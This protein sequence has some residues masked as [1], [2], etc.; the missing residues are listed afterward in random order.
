MLTTLDRYLLREVIQTWVAVTFVLL[1]IMLS[2]R[3][4][5]Y[6]GEAAAGQLPAEVV[7]TLLGLTS[8]QY[9]TVLVP[10]SLFLAVMLALGRFYRDSEMVA[11]MACGIGYGRLLKPLM[12]LA[13]TIGV[14]LAALSLQVGPWAARMASEVRAGAEREVESAGFEAGRFR[15]GGETVYYAEQVSDSGRELRDVF[16]EQR[17]GDRI[18]VSTAERAAQTVDAETGVRHLVLYDGRRYLHTPGSP[19]YQLIEFE[20][21]GVRIDP[22]AIA[23]AIERRAARRTW[24]LWNSDDPADVAELQWRVSVPL[25]G[26]VL[27]ALAVPLGRASPRQG[28]YAK[29]VAAILLYIVYSNLLGISQA[30]IERGRIEPWIGL[31][32]VHAAIV[33]VTVVLVLRHYGW[34]YV[35]NRQ[36]QIGSHGAGAH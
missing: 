2:S 1:A 4:A 13:L 3:F 23:D 8:V 34:R 30:W 9:L 33:V 31:W 15:T 24:M 22:P 19:E 26:V 27:V 20:E 36:S 21:H 16:I 10:V 12:A 28:R 35:L 25:M 18:V 29:L 5:R 6:L 7:F 17:D 14:G 32:W 11:M